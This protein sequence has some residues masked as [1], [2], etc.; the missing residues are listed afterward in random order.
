MTLVDN[1]KEKGIAIFIK[2]NSRW[3]LEISN[4]LQLK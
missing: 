4:V 2:S 3:V 1:L